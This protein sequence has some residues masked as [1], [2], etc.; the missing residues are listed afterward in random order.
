MKIKSSPSRK[1]FIVFNYVFLTLIMVISLFPLVHMLALSLSS[2]SA[3]QAG[4]VSIFPVQFTLDSY[5]YILSKAEFFRSFGIS[6]LRVILGTSISVFLTIISAYALSQPDAKFHGR[7]IYTWMFMV[8][9][10]FNGGLV[11]TFIVIK[12][13][14]LYDSLLALILPSAVQVFNIILMLNFF[15]GLPVALSESAFIDGANHFQVL[16]KIF[17]PIS[18][19][20]LATVGLFTMVFHWNSWFDGMIYL[21]DTNKYPLQTYLKNVIRSVDMASIN[22]NSVADLDQISQK[23]LTA[24]QIFVAIIPILIVYP[25]L[26]KHFIAGMTLGSVKE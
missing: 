24:A 15:R 21:S 17:L 9:M 3:A 8:T 14:G 11:P 19:P 26:Q 4:W 13:V 2:S 18:K 5:K 10:V 22:I 16:F 7:K 1:V 23:T 20:S 25:L 6:V 12:T